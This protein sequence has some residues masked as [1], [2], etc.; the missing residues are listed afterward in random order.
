MMVLM[1]FSSDK[2][3]QMSVCELRECVVT[4]EEINQI[5]IIETGPNECVVE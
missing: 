1:T 3:N 4:N 2:M 5:L